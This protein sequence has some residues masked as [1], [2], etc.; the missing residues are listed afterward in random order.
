MKSKPQRQE[1]TP[2][3]PRVSATRLL[4]AT[5][6]QYYL[7]QKYLRTPT[8]HQNLLCSKLDSTLQLIFWNFI[9]EIF[10]RQ[11]QNQ[12]TCWLEM[13]SLLT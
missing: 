12:E 10:F 1:D 9:E 3:E 8:L 11:L 2:I 5:Q 4:R 7:G 13:L 6:L